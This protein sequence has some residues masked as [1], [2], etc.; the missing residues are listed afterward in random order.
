MTFWTSR[1]SINKATLLL[2]KITHQLITVSFE[3]GLVILFV[4]DSQWKETTMR[5]L[6]KIGKVN[7]MCLLSYTERIS[8]I[9]K[10]F[11]AFCCRRTTISDTKHIRQQLGVAT[12]ET[13]EHSHNI[14]L[15]WAKF[16]CV[17]YHGSH[18]HNTWLNCLDFD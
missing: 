17:R 12:Q 16:E 3:A 11:I 18:K 10:W 15:G 1:F 5:N 2:L 6:S 13:S 7:F 14:A 9:T 8:F 4:F